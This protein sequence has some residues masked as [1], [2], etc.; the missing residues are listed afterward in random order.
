MSEKLPQ[1]AT[2]TPGHLGAHSCHQVTQ[3]GSSDARGTRQV[4]GP[5]R[6]PVLR[7]PWVRALWR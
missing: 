7:A 2:H 3:T 1:R 6:P 4:L 5:R